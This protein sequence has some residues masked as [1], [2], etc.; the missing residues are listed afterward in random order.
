VAEL[1]T[2]GLGGDVPGA[3]AAARRA[4]FELRDDQATAL[5]ALVLVMLGDRDE[6]ANTMRLI[7]ET[8]ITRVPSHFG[9]IARVLLLLNGLSHRLAPGQMIVQRALVETLAAQSAGTTDGAKA[10]GLPPGPTAPPLL[11]VLRWVQWPLPFLDECAQR[12]GE[13]FTL[14]FPSTPPIVMFAH[15]DAIKTIFTGDEE[16]LRAGEA[17][18]RLEPILGKHSLLT[19]DGHE[20]LRERRLLQPPFHGDRMLA[21]GA[22]MRDIAA[23]A[24]DRW[25][26]GRPFAVHPEMQGVT[27]D[28]ILRTVFGLDE[29]PTKRDLRAALLDLLNLG[30]NPQLLLA[31]QQ[32]NG[33]GARPAERFFAAR[34]RVDRLLFAEIAAR[35]LADVT[36]RPDILSLLVQATYENGRPLEDQALRDELMTILLAGHE[37]TATSLAWA[38]SHVLAHPEVRARIADELRELGPAPLDPQRVTRLEYLDAVCRETLRLT[39]I[40]PL[41]GRRLTRPMRIGGV[42]L[43]AGV[44]AAPCIYLAHRRPERWPEPERFRPERFLETKPTPYEFLPFGGGV[45][46]CLGMAFALVEMK[47]VLAEVLTRVEL[48]AAPGYQVRVVRRSVTLAPSEGMPVVVEGRAA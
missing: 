42:D 16:D 38:V 46:R 25:P 44:V 5:P 23:A 18:Y 3:V 36:D 17:N 37:T 21:Y 7:Q 20:H 48:R 29:G 8:P 19:L 10:D 14:R 43:P 11:Q 4:G 13:T 9:L 34:E 40:I 31:A 41:V 30:A 1:V 12:F 22:V 39:P 15:P 26:A 32:S 47:I 27:L 33:N 2:R 35:R 28:V 6:Q 45:R 24:V